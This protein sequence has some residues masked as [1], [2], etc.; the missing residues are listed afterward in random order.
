MSY[1]IIKAKKRGFV[2]VFAL[3]FL[4]NGPLRAQDDRMQQMNFQNNIQLFYSILYGNSDILISTIYNDVKYGMFTLSEIKKYYLELTQQVTYDSILIVIK[5]LTIHD[6]GL[7]FTEYAILNFSN[8]KK[9]YLELGLDSP[10]K[11]IGIWLN[12]GD[13]LADLIKNEKPDKL[14]WEGIINIKNHKEWLE[15]HELP[16][17]NSKITVKLLPNQIFTY[18]PIGDKDWWPVVDHGHLLGFIQKND[19]VMYLN[20]PKSLKDKF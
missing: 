7:H 6:D 14:L 12:N 11:I 8:G 17:T 9:I 19:V 10:V 15:L 18:T 1:I 3:L 16:S 5:N 4:I 2:I 20:F 13:D